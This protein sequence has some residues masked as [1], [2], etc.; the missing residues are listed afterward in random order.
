M[1]L[2]RFQ[3]FALLHANNGM[4]IGT[5]GTL[6]GAWTPLPQDTASVLDIGTG[7]GLLAFMLAQRLPQ[8]HVVGID[9]SAIN[10]EEAKENLKLNP[11]FSDR[12]SVLQT[13]LQDFEPNGK[14]DG[15]IC[16]PPFYQD[17][18]SS[19]SENR[20]LARNLKH[21]PP[22]ELFASSFRLINEAGWMSTIVPYEILDRTLQA[23]TKAG[24]HL[25]ACCLVKG[26]AAKPP[27]RALL[28]FVKMPCKPEESMLVLESDHRKK[29]KE[30]SDLLSDFL[31]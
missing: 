18:L 7:T 1:S 19:E 12:I 23:G 21:L 22:E 3:Q 4:K 2:F 15:I 8:A 6:L 16:N 28:H 27:K 31:L 17:K 5:D 26:R 29:S 20:D 14:F 24:F 30:F 9:P 11:T 13:R 25:K 10:T